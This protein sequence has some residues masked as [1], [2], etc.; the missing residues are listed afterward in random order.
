MNSNYIFISL[1]A[2]VMIGAIVGCS[3]TKKEKRPQ[4]VATDVPTFK[5]IIERPDIQLV[6]AR[7]P[8]EYNEGHIG[9]AINI[10]VLAED[11]IPKA[12][13]LL[14]KEKPIAVYCRSGKRSTIAAEKLAAAGFSGPIYN[15]TGG[16]LAYTAQE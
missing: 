1:V 9:N 12:T 14:K 3:L 4:I 5:K 15:L 2:L 13:Q 8:K 10:D 11:F 7:T 16:Y 6:D